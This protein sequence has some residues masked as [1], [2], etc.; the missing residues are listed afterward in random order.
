MDLG[1]AIVK[2]DCIR[3]RPSRGTDSRFVNYALMQ[4]SLAD[5]VAKHVRGV[6]RSR[7]GLTNVRR[8]PMP[9]ADPD[10]QRRIADVLDEKLA[11]LARVKSQFD[12]ALRR[13]TALRRAILAAA[14]SGQLVPQYPD[15]EP[16]SVLL[17]RIRA[18]RA[19]AP[20][21]QRIRRSEAS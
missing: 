6:G 14:F 18:E 3:V 11:L 19:E 17:D 9:L 8:I 1:P 20:P 15:D 2:A 13:A 12:E 10:V 4:S 16:A 7:L 21:N 5:F